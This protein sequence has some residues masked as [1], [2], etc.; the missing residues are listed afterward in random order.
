MAHSRVLVQELFYKPTV[1]IGV[2]QV[3]TQP[4]RSFSGTAVNNE[5]VNVLTVINVDYS[6][7]VFVSTINLHIG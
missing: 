4:I 1:A 5:F 2:D 3:P 6:G 7:D